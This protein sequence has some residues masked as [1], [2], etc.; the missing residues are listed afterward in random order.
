[1]IQETE[2][3]LETAG[4]YRAE[5]AN[6]DRRAIL[7]APL[8]NAGQHTDELKALLGP[9]LLEFQKLVSLLYDFDKDIVE[10]IATL[11]AVW[12][13]GL[14][15]GDKPDDT[16][17]IREFLTEWHPDKERFKEEELR[18]WLAWMRRND[19][20]PRGQGPR[21]AHTMTRDLFAS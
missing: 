14:I 5:P 3:G 2:R 16:T 9:R 18:H 11:Y 13:D 4:V 10:A 21:T 20:I 17:I 8:T 12:N 1:L 7:Y 15:D 19:L 6:Q